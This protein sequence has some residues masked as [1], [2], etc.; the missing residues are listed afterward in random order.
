MKFR[1]NKGSVSVEASLVL[2]IFLFTM[3]F[4][5]YICNVN[6]VKGVIYEGCIETAEY[7]AEY[8]YLTHHF[9][10]AELMDYP[11][12]AVRF[13]EYV[14]DN[15]LL[16]KYV[17]GGRNG[18]CFVGSN[19]PDGDGFI[20]LRVTYY[21]RLKL[22]IFGNF[23]RRCEEHIR[24]KAYLGRQKPEESDEEEE[25]E[26][27]Y[28]YV[29]KNGTVYHTTRSCT[30]LSPK[31]QSSSLEDARAGGYKPCEYCGSSA[32]ELVY[33]TPY[34]DRYHSTESCSRIKRTIY[35]KKLSEVSLPPCSKCGG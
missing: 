10:K 12:A 16:D 13:R 28:V 9:E 4:F 1:K 20:D 8:S 27:K 33:I 31:V 22:P 3:L 7:M 30:Y 23:T 14:D 26:D 29:T 6:T 2:P 25:D 24:Q 32:G 21:I 19:F 17:I 11:M 5:I 35:R 34:G 18:V 15:A